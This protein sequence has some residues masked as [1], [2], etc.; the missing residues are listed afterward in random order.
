[1]HCDRFPES[2]NPSRSFSAHLRG[3]SPIGDDHR[4]DDGDV[5]EVPELTDTAYVITPR[6]LRPPEGSCR[7]AR[8]ACKYFTDIAQRIAFTERASWLAVTTVCFD[9]AASS[10][11]ATLFRGKVI[12]VSEEQVRIGRVLA[13]IIH[14]KKPTSCRRHRLHGE[15]WLSPAGQVALTSPYFVAET[16]STAI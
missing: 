10:S 9:I 1:M 11:F 15:F 12:L 3:G 14:H 8:G 6:A 13:G 7:H 5:L 2:D 4:G 16:A